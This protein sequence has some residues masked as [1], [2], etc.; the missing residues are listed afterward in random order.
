MVIQMNESAWCCNSQRPGAEFSQMTEI[1]A[2]GENKVLRPWP[3][4]SS[5][6]AKEGAEDTL[7]WAFV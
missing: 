5:S 6:D 4:D 3:L 1:K 2:S 7:A